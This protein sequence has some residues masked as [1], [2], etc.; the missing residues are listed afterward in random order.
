[1]LSSKI[2][3]LF[4]SSNFK[5]ERELES[6]FESGDKFAHALSDFPLVITSTI[7]ICL[8]KTSH[9]EVE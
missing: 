9:E 4:S 2:T 3:P 5:A 6:T 8:V 1:M 7:V